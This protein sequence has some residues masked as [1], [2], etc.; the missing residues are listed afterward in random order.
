MAPGPKLPRRLAWES[1]CGRFLVEVCPSAVGSEAAMML[2][3]RWFGSSRHTPKN[4][5]RSLCNGWR[6]GN[7]SSSAAFFPRMRIKSSG[8]PVL[9]GSP[10]AVAW[11][12]VHLIKF[13]QPAFFSGGIGIEEVR[14]AGQSQGMVKINS[15]ECKGCGL[16]V[17]ACP[18][19]CLDLEPGLNPYGVHP[20]GFVGEDKCTGCGICFYNC[21]EPGAITVYRAVPR[22][23]AKTEACHET[24]V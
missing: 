19:K 18:R 14:M 24:T 23:P 9:L 22:Q 4:W 20:A 13:L 11:T 8:W 3:Y 1:C 16:C 5:W 17:E 21:P 10:P 12:K 2:A 15:D 7:A 6:K